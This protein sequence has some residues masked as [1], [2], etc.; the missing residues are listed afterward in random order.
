[1]KKDIFRCQSNPVDLYNFRD[2]STVRYREN[3]RE[4]L[5]NK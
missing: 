5:K 1:M 4:L 2:I 3:P